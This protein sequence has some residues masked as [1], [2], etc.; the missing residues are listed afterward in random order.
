MYFLIKPH[1]DAGNGKKDATRKRPSSRR[2]LHGIGCTRCPAMAAIYSGR[3]ICT[4]SAP[5]ISSAPM[6]SPL[7]AAR[8]EGKERRS[9]RPGPL[10]RKNARHHNGDGCQCFP[11]T[12]AARQW[13]T[14]SPGRVSAARRGNLYACQ[15]GRENETIHTP[16]PAPNIGTHY[17]GEMPVIITATAARHRLPYLHGCPLPPGRKI[18]RARKKARY[19]EHSRT[20]FLGFFSYVIESMTYYI[21]LPS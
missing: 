12:P 15:A 8:Q 21:I 16:A 3:G 1:R 10:P 13:L 6:L 2:Q 4:G 18:I 9:T 14:A 7:H 20:S 19:S 11:A 5:G 17:P